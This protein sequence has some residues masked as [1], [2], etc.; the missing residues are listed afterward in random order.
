MSCWKIRI[1]WLK[2]WLKHHVRF[3]KPWQSQWP[4]RWKLRKDLQMRY[5][6][7]APMGGTHI[8]GR[9]VSVAPKSASPRSVD[10]QT[11]NPRSANPQVAPKSGNW[12]QARTSTESKSEA[13]SDS[14]LNLKRIRP[15]NNRLGAIWSLLKPFEGKSNQ[16]RYT[17]VMFVKKLIKSLIHSQI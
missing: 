5:T 16:I 8:D 15:C 4:T 17:F 9:W 7:P 2:P 14:E 11:V 10:P 6:F 3:L 1:H 13:E 12:T